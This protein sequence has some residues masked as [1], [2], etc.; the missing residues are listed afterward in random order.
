M[1][2][3]KNVSITAKMRIF[4]IFTLFSFAEILSATVRMFSQ[5]SKLAQMDTRLKSLQV[6][7]LNLESAGRD[8]ATTSDSTLIDEIDRL[9]EKTQKDTETIR[10]DLTRNKIHLDSIAMVPSVMSNYRDIIRS[11]KYAVSASDNALLASYRTDLTRFLYQFDGVY[12]T[13]EK[14]YNQD[15]NNITSKVTM[16]FY[17]ANGA[18]ILILIV[19]SLIILRSINV[20]MRN[21]MNALPNLLHREGEKINLSQKIEIKANDELGKISGMV[22]N[23]MLQLNTDFGR[24]FHVLTKL[25]AS[26]VDLETATNA[27]AKEAESI[28][29][30]IGMISNNVEQQT[31]GVEEVSSTLE[32]MK[33]NLDNIAISIERQSSAVEESASTI[34]EMGRNNENIAKVSLQTRDISNNLSQVALKGGE[35]VQESVASILDASEYSRQILK[36]LKLITDIAKQT[37]L[38]AMNASIEAAH[39]GEAGKGFAIVA[40]EIRRLSE[41]TNKNAKE[42]GDVV[43]T[44]VEKIDR[45]AELSKGAGEGLVNIENYAKQSENTI[46]QL[47]LMI[48]EQSTSIRDILQATESIVSVTEEVKIAMFEQKTGVDEF[49]VTMNSLKD[50]FLESKASIDSHLDSLGKLIGFIEQTDGIVRENSRVFDELEGL[51]ANF[52]IRTDEVPEETSIKLVE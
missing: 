38:L 41:T 20:P 6:D 3:L 45:S 4:V 47:N 10:S 29:A 39:A 40:D 46:K 49:S 36:L 52:D 21:L 8:Y 43:A 33:R 19:F 7:L 16:P 42:I 50:L 28:S 32:E 48:E 35:A 11:I 25:N 30:S 14:D 9:F 15:W 22:N 2:V 17:I 12:E 51:L 5:Y 1:A 18:I 26:K 24:I 34:E 44:I 13:L 27:E 31:S 23:L 37:N